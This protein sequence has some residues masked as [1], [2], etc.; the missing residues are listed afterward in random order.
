MIKYLCKMR[1][2]TRFIWYCVR[3][4]KEG[5]RMWGNCSFGKDSLSQRMAQ[6]LSNAIVSFIFYISPLTQTFNCPP[7]IAA[8]RNDLNN[9]NNMVARRYDLRRPT[10]LSIRRINLTIIN[11]PTLIPPII[12]ERNRLPTGPEEHKGHDKNYNLRS[13]IKTCTEHIIEAQEPL[14]LISSKV[15]LRPQSNDEEREDGGVNTGY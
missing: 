1:L 15:K 9:K 12:R 8:P 14:R 4:K 3:E 5:T 10:S 2:I 13:T 6:N 11:I 7:I